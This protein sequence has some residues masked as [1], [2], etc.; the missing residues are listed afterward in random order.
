MVLGSQ[1]NARGRQRVWEYLGAVGCSTERCQLTLF[2]ECVQ[3][4]RVLADR[5][6]RVAWETCNKCAASLVNYQLRQ[7]SAKRAH[8]LLTYDLCHVRERAVQFLCRVPAEDRYTPGCRGDQRELQAPFLE[9]TRLQDETRSRRRPRGGNISVAP[10]HS[11]YRPHILSR[12]K[13]IWPHGRPP[14]PEIQIT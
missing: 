5:K 11:R 1:S 13:G 6:R 14:A 8:P 12:R 10:S 9:K 4:L 2:L 3:M 7:R